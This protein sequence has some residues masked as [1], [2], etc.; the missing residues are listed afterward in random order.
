MPF[1]PEW[2]LKYKKD[3]APF[4]PFKTVTEARHAYA[5][6]YRGSEEQTLALWCWMALSQV[7]VEKAR[8]VEEAAH[9]YAAAPEKS[10]AAV[11]G[12]NKWDEYAIIAARHAATPAEA[13]KAHKD[14][15]QG[16][17]AQAVAYER[18]EELSHIEVENARSIAACKRA[19]AR[20]PQLYSR[21]A[22][23]AARRKWDELA[24]RRVKRV[25]TYD[26][27]C[28]VYELCPPGLQSQK[29]AIQKINALFPGEKTEGKGA[30][31]L[32]D[33]IVIEMVDG[34]ERACITTFATALKRVREKPN[35]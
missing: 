32:K 19:L 11:L 13:Q 33:R 18:W 6:C 8:T 3:A 16:S 10:K 5:Q 1:R 26:R 25:R 28:V 29:L 4:Q 15:R 14:A 27:A 23:H 21:P 34:E 7:E 22:W 20:A 35:S 24:M 31:Y 30:V 9:A 17:E 12:R 2:Y